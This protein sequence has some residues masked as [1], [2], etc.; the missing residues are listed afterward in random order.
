MSFGTPAAA[1]YLQGRPGA[2]RP[3]VPLVGTLAAAINQVPPEAFLS[4]A[5]QLA[6][7][8][9][10]AQ[11]LFDLDAV[12]VVSD[13]MLVADGLGVS[14]EWD[15][16]DDRFATVEHVAFVDELA[17]PNT[18]TDAGRIPTVLDAA[19]RLVTSLDDVAV[20][21]V[22][23]GPHTTFEAVFGETV[24]GDDARTTPIRTATGE[25]ARAFGQNGVD[26]FLVI[27]SPPQGGTSRDSDAVDAAVETLDVLD[28]IGEFFGTVLGVA[29]GGYTTNAVE[30][31]VDATAVDAVFLDTDDPSEMSETLNG[32][33][34]GG[35][36]TA[37]LLDSD[38]DEIE[39]I[40]EKT[41]ADLPSEVFLA[42]GVE[43]PSEVHPRKLQAVHRAVETATD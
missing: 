13:P 8:L 9:Q 30:S 37:S 15:E 23:P 3:F 7:G 33:R 27:E 1:E 14:V 5:T 32:V 19:D 24:E 36:I 38:D 35:G 10:R 29:P 26:G 34:V 31:L 11:R 42:S 25:V 41:V 18:I 12:C 40:V 4:D 16:D 43:V 21:A 22:L 39:R 28:N 2:D 6:N 17:D 20:F